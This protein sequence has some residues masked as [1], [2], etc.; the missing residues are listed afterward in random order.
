MK[1]RNLRAE[2]RIVFQFPLVPKYP[3]PGPDSKLSDFRNVIVKFIVIYKLLCVWDGMD[4][5]M[6][7]SLSKRVEY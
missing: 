5:W 1:V 7:K 3:K 4:G 2:N 6:E